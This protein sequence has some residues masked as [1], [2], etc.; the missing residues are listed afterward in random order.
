MIVHFV[1]DATVIT[2]ERFVIF[3]LNKR[4]SKAYM[5]SKLTSYHTLHQVLFYKWFLERIVTQNLTGDVMLILGKRGSR[6]LFQVA[7]F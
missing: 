5:L 3:I 1:S 6:M 4:F 7:T 2:E